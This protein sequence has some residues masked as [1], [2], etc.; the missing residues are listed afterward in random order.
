METLQ[1]IQSHRNQRAYAEIQNTL[2]KLAQVQYL[3]KHI[4]DTYPNSEDF[5]KSR[6]TTHNI[7]GPAILLQTV[8][9]HFHIRSGYSA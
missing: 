1:Q 5:V 7:S 2:H 3:E 4:L 8:N 9:T 6:S